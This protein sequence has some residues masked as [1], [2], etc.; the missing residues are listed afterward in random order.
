MQTHWWCPGDDIH[1][2]MSCG[3]RLQYLTYFAGSYFASCIWTVAKGFCKGIDWFLGPNKKTRWLILLPCFIYFGKCGQHNTICLMQI[4][5][6]CR[7]HSWSM[8][9]KRPWIGE[10]RF[11]DHKAS[12]VKCTI[13]VATLVHCKLVL[14]SIAYSRH[15]AGI[16]QPPH[17]MGSRQLLHHDWVSM[18]MLL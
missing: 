3:T 6:A 9:E 1:Y 12:A 8:L 13:Y 18:S 14:F 11:Q 16:C 5:L 10:C 4:G 17:R 7:A 2:C 15:L